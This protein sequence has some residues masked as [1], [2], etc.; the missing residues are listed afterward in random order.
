M[1]LQLLHGMAT[2]LALGLW[3]SERDLAAQARHLGQVNPEAEARTTRRLVEHGFENVAVHTR[4]ETLTVWYENRI[5]RNEL[6]AVGVAALLSTSE[7]RASGTIEL[8]PQNLGVPLLSISASVEHWLDFL[9]ANQTPSQFRQHV[10]I[11]TSAAAG[12][13][14]LGR[15]VPARS[16]SSHWKL[17]FTVRPLL[18]FELGIADDPLQYSLRIAPELTTSPRA[19]VLVTSQVSFLVRDD[20]DP[21]A[22]QAAPGRTTLSW[23]G[24]LPGSWLFIASGGSFS[25]NRYGLAAATGRYL[26]GGTL[27][28]GVDAD[29]SGSLRF[30]DGV[31]LYSNM[32]TW[33]C[34]VSATHHTR[35]IDLETTLAAARFMEGDL[36]TQ[37]SLTR[38]YGETEVG[39][40]GILTRKDSVAG[41]QLELPLPGQRL[42]EPSR[43]RLSSIPSLPIRYRD[44]LRNVG[45][46]VSHFN[47]LD[48]LREGLDPT[49]VLNNIEA[50]RDAR[51]HLDA[52]VP[53]R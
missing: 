29:L 2:I 5:Y 22:R 50:L 24:R 16:H 37:L 43:V 3:G 13:S 26:L 35:G 11:R 6:T 25:G 4:G 7:V 36:G 21:F 30:A 23:A 12:G 10:Q 14:A 34:A 53:A 33:S 20:I 49:Y 47:D 42:P 31:T 46:R 44:S 28:I 40:F 41:I 45:I 15:R 8:I 1:G 51:S 27:E 17:D 9:V 48:W 39:F 32:S 19:G 38:R 52:G 18:A